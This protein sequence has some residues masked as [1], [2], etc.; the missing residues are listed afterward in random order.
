MGKGKYGT[1]CAVEAKFKSS[2]TWK[3]AVVVRDNGKDGVTVRFQDCGDQVWLPRSS[4]RRKHGARAGVKQMTLVKK[5]KCPTCSQL[6]KRN[7]YSRK[8]WN[9]AD[10]RCKGCVMQCKSECYEPCAESEQQQ[11]EQQQAEQQ[12]AWAWED[13]PNAPPASDPGQQEAEEGLEQAEPWEGQDSQ[14]KLWS[15]EEQEEH[16]AGSEEEQEGDD[17]WQAA[18]SA[19]HSEKDALQ[20]ALAIRDADVAALESSKKQLEADSEAL[21]ELRAKL[22]RRDVLIQKHKKVQVDMKEDLAK[23]EQVQVDMKEDLAKHKSKNQQFYEENSR[24]HSKVLEL[25]S[26][27]KKYE[28]V[29]DFKALEER[30]QRAEAEATKLAAEKEAVEAEL[31]QERAVEVFDVDTGGTDIVVREDSEPVPKRQRRAQCAAMQQASASIAT[32]KKEKAGLQCQLKEKESQLKE[33]ES[34]VRVIT[35][36]LGYEAHQEFQKQR[37]EEMSTDLRDECPICFLSGSHAEWCT[38]QS[39]IHP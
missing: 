9:K 19:L 23:H 36:G 17:P 39:G 12:Q 33:K 5:W 7:G 32:I 18:Y 28:R 15:E 14:E 10:G 30:A 22:D 3:A 1:G 29:G 24:L 37:A 21:P 8:Q 2:R 20:N 35:G 4:V 25:A 27:L 38:N 13:M 31:L 16:W 6:F 11:S 26:K 34:Q